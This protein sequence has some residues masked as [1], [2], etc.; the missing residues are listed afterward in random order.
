MPRT[1]RKP[2]SKPPRTGATPTPGGLQCPDCDF[3]ARH[4]MGLG[5]HRSTKHGVISQRQARREAAGG[6]LTRREAARRANVH[7]NTIRHWER[8][9]RVRTMRQPGRGTLVS[10]FDLQQI[11]TGGR[12][13]PSGS[14]AVDVE[15]IQA[16]EKRFN[17]LLRGLERLASSARA[18]RRPGAAPAAAPAARTRRPASA[19][20]V[21][22]AARRARARRRR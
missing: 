2:A 22:A 13:R 1:R 7:Y 11:L 10:A 16:L 9:G 21:V 12:A 4:P 17:A 3:V 20:A 5:R 15:R 14:P 18:E 6:W 8:T 19:G